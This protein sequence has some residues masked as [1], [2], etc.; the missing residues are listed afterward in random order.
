VTIPCPQCGGE[1][2][3]QDTSGF[4][5]CPY[6][7]TSLILDLSGVH[8]HLLY[9]PRHGPASVLPLVRRW[10][11]AE[12]LPPASL[13][14]P[15]QL[16]YYP[17]WRFLGPGRP[18]LVPA[19]PTLD[20]RWT[21]FPAPDAEQVVYDPAA[22]GAARVVEATVTEAAARVRDAHGAEGP[23]GDLV[24]IPVYEVPI[25]L[26]KERVTLCMDACAGRPLLDRSPGR[27]GGSPEAAWRLGGILTAS[28]LLMFLA[29]AGIPNGWLAAV[30]VA[31]LGVGAYWGIAARTGEGAG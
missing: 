21:D 1:V 16:V 11:D 19:W 22:V 15:P 17:F 12:R 9:R 2:R 24:H 23:G 18:R 20:T 10:C 25:R 6:C 4:V 26:G 30:A 7:G 8:P 14:S 28:W 31:V 29:A 13:L 27:L 5:R 3:L